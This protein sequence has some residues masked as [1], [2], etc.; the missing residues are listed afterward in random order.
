MYIF[1]TWVVISEQWWWY[2]FWFFHVHTYTLVHLPLLSHSHTYTLTLTHTLTHTLT[3]THSHSH[4]HTH[5]HRALGVSGCSATNGNCPS[6]AQL[7]EDNLLNEAQRGICQRDG[8]TV[9]AVSRG[10]RKAIIDCQAQFKNLKWNC[11]TFY[12]D[13]LFGSFVN[14]G[15]LDSLAVI[16]SDLS[17]HKHVP[18]R[19]A[20]DC[21]LCVC[22]CVG[23]CVCMMCSLHCRDLD[24]IKVLTAQDVFQYCITCHIELQ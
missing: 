13:N 18:C 5:S 21:S 16:G 15:M 8:A 17:S 23:V 14:Q 9:T 12:G 7:N 20:C 1:S 2:L 24:F 10:A 6:C 22:V 4:T 11:S 19:F 3:L